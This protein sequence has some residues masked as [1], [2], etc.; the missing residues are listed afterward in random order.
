[1]EETLRKFKENLLNTGLF[2][3]AYGKEYNCECPFCGDRRKHCYVIIDMTDD[4]P[5]MYNCFKCCAKGKVDQKFLSY[6][7]LNNIQLPK[8]QNSRKLD[9]NSS[10]TVEMIGTTVDEKDNISRVCEYIAR[11]V[12][13]YPT[14]EELQMFQY[15]GNPRKYALDYLGYD[16]EG[17]PFTN[18]NWFKLTNGNII[19]R[20]YNDDT[21]I[22]WLRFKSP[23]VSSAGM[24]TMKKGFEIDKQINVCIAEGIMDV[25]GLY[26]N[27]PID[28][29]IYIATM[30]KNYERGIK[31]ILN[32]GIFGDSVNIKVFKDSDVPINSIRINPVLEKLFKSVDI[33][34]NIAGHDFGETKDKMDIKKIIRR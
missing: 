34:E 11:K 27:F 32:R 5:V 4:T 16:G 6:F 33:Y 3:H 8:Y 19:G 2:R 13:H 26:Y 23:R 25:I 31:H 12:S 15:V 20:W 24:Y 18:R 9:I 30:G 1:M 29:P 21:P 22:R 17:R 28:N 7:D 14:L 10:V